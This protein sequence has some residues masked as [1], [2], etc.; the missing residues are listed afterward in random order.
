M[1]DSNTPNAP[2]AG[3]P[4][5]AVAAA[6]PS[7]DEKTMAML[8]HLLGGLVGFLAPLIIWLLKKETM[9]FVDDQGKEALNFQITMLFAFIAC[10]IIAAVTCGFGGVLIP[11]VW[12]ADLV[13]GIMAG[14]KA[15]EG[16]TY[17]YPFAVRLI[18]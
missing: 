7:K 14:M 18:K 5:P 2:A 9:P 12:L 15:N 6:G 1:A 13:L 16:I 8:C 17:R 10:G 11:L 3:Q 4:A